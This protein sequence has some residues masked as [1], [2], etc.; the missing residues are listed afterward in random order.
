MEFVS[1][2]SNV[3]LKR[4][5]AAVIESEQIAAGRFSICLMH[6]SETV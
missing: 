2:D 3:V 6:E 5:C 4:A 1:V